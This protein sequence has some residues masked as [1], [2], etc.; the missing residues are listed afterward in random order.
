MTTKAEH[1]HLSFNEGAREVLDALYDFT[2]CERRDGSR[3]GTSGQCRKGTETAAEK[4]GLLSKAKSLAKKAVRKVTGAEKREKAAAEKKAEEEKVAKRKAEATRRRE[5]TDDMIN[6]ISKDVPAGTEIK[7]VGGTLQLSRT[8]RAGHKI[9]YHISRTGNVEF[10]VNGTWDA[11]SVKN[12]KEQVEVA[13]NVKRMHEAVVK[14][15]RP[16]HEL[17]TNAW[18]EDGKGD[19]RMKAYEAMGFSKAQGEDNTMAARRTND[20]KLEPVTGKI[21]SDSFLMKDQDFAESEVND[22]KLWF[23]AIFGEEI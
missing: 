2:V 8:T 4:P 16:G 13:L 12:R 14:N 21:S 3:Y 6:R 7:N 22:V 1:H 9:D 11:G 19:A 5:N 23:T 15:L 20:G 10:S 18:A 17:W